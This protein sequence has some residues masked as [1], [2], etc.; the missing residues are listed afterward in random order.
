MSLLVLL[1]LDFH[2]LQLLLELP[3]EIFQ[4][5]ELF[6][7]RR[8]ALLAIVSYGFAI[9]QVLLLANRRFLLVIGHRLTKLLQLLAHLLDQPV[10][11]FSEKILQIFLPLF[12]PV[13]DALFDVPAAFGLRTILVSQQRRLLDL[14]SQTVNFAAAVRHFA[15]DFPTDL[16]HVALHVV[17]G[18]LELR[19]EMLDPRK[20]V[21]AR[22]LL[23]LGKA[24]EAVQ[25]LFDAGKLS[26]DNDLSHAL[27]LSGRIAG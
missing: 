18:R 27:D 19:F 25:P 12:Q 26:A 22:K 1:V 15:G 20:N 7:L 4:P 3:D 6:L 24:F 9:K 5:F 10:F 11:P 23:A 14:F 8:Q 21:R 17:T 13:T 2:D 16:I